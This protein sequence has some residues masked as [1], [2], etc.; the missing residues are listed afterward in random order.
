MTT[1][2]IENATRI[3]G[4]D[5]VYNKV[6]SPKA[7]V[8]SGVKKMAAK[9]DGTCA[10]CTGKIHA[11]EEIYYNVN[12][13]RAIHAGC[14]KAAIEAREAAEKAA[15]EAKA[16]QPVVNGTYTVVFEDGTRRTIR[17]KAGTG[18][19][20][21]RQVVSYL[22]GPNNEADYVGFG[23]IAG[24]DLKVWRR[25]SNEAEGK[26][27]HILTALALLRTSGRAEEFG[28]AYALESGNC[29]KCGRTL[30][31]PESVAAGI[32]PKCASK[33]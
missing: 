12:T 30:T 8:Q 18:A 6:Y 33:L 23:T 27:S 17:V 1:Y 13:R 10:R 3:F 22:A 21:G 29:W 9:Y 31:T 25:F 32:G 26:R 28:K 24:T 14:T 4:R 16:A 15:R 2:N 5:E 19:F 7:P 20:E 11:G